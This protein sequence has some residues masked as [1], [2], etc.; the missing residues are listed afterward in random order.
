MR[1]LWVPVLAALLLSACSDDDSDAGTD[2]TEFCQLLDRL[3]R[4]DP[5]LV[6]GDRASPADIQVAFEALVERADELLDAAPE[7]SRA[8]ARDYAESADALD[9]LLAGAAYDGT[10]VDINAYR[11][12]QT[13]Y[14][15]AAE[16]LERYLESEC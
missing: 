2:D 16:R 10:N 13:T 7:E 6:F 1:R 3:T 15:A 8:A 11:E 9:S 14:A 4:N 5:F 12:Q